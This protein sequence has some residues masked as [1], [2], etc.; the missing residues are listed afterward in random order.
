MNKES[1]SRLAAWCAFGFALFCFLLLFFILSNLFNLKQSC[2]V[3]SDRKVG[4][5][6]S[7]RD[8]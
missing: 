3:G 6:E 1:D 2:G 7:R 4:R 5:E 8:E